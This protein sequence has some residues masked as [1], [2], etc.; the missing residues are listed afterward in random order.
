MHCPMSVRFQK[1]LFSYSQA[2]D[3]LPCPLASIATH[4]FSSPR[5]ADISGFPSDPFSHSHPSPRSVLAQAGFLLHLVSLLPFLFQL[6][7]RWNSF[8]LSD[9]L[10]GAL[11]QSPSEAFR[12]PP[13][14]AGRGTF[15]FLC[16]CNTWDTA[17]PFILSFLVKS[18]SFL[19]FFC[20][21]EPHFPLS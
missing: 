11:M 4:S 17:L 1:L 13:L 18:L 9:N 10:P 2:R 19:R 14:R 16:R 5:S 6:S 7:A 21:R 12:F 3:G 8:L 15:L 20:L